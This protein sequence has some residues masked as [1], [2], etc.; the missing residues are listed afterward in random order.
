MRLLRSFAMSFTDLLILFMQPYCLAEISRTPLNSQEKRPSVPSKLTF[1]GLRSPNR[2]PE[3]N[4]TTF[5]PSMSV[6]IIA[7]R[8]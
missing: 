4:S 3:Q 7:S 1:Q 2:I 6:F 5:C 8:H